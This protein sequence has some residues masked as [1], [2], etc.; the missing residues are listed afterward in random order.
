M[1]LAL[2][3]ATEEDAGQIL[4]IYAPIVR[5]T[6]ISFEVEPPS[7]AAMRQRITDTL[8][9]FPWL[10]CERY[11]ELQGYAFAGRHRARAAYRWS[12]DVSV[13][14]HAQARRSG[15]GR[16]LYGA[17]FR[18]LTMQGFFNAFAG[19]ALPNPASVRLHES[20]GFQPVG[21][22]RSV[23][24][25]RGA[26]HDVGWWQLSLQPH[27][28]RPAPP[29]DFGVLRASREWEAALQGTRNQPCIPP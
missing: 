1:T 3:L 14:V 23:G 4:A 24:Y 26:W 7:A 5:D 16:A 2:R 6:P 21:I 25:K 19:I 11:G 13:Y 12:V 10:A 8:A 18:V 9:C 28:A 17:L 27:A 15:V 29:I 22:Y 20:L